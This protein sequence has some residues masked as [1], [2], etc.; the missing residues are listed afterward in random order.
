MRNTVVERVVDFYAFHRREGNKFV[1]TSRVVGIAVRP[2]AEDLAECTIVDFEED[3]IEEFVGT[4]DDRLEKQVQGNTAVARATPK[5]TAANCWMPLI[6]T[7]CPATRIHAAVVDH[8]GI[9]ET[10]G[11]S[12]FPNAACNCT[13]NT[14]IP[15]FPPGTAPAVSADARPD[16]ILTRSKPSASLRRLRCGCMKSAPALAWWARRHAPQ[17]GGTLPERG[18]VS[19]HQAARQFFGC[20]RTCR[21]LLERG[22]GEYGF[23]HLTF[24]EYLAAVALALMRTGRFRTDYRTLSRHVGEQ[25]WRE[26]TLLTIGYLGIRQQLP[27]IAGEVVEALV[28][29]QPGPPGEAVVLAGDAV[30]D[31]WP[32]GVPLQSKDRVIQS[33]V[34]TMQDGAIRPELRRHAGL[35]LGRLG[36]RPGDLDRFVE[37]PAG[38]Y[39]AG[40][41]KEAMEIRICISSPS[42]RSRTS[43]LRASSRRT[44]YQTREYWS[45]LGWEWRTGKYDCARFKMWNATGWSIAR[46]QNGMCRITGTT[47]S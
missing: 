25:A 7:R 29:Q 16:A 6:T 34:D 5:L 12:R 9:D 4:L 18:D 37:V 28:E 23:I 46:P 20:A 32:G 30:L 47:S 42:I 15:C 10:A 45:E 1:L 8:S 35:L 24:E 26:V 2:S 31:T 19:P 27:K 43:S 33:L 13:T 11:R 22:P 14:S 41:K 17:T 44:G 38:E 40:V 21:L 3:E 39:Q 36:W